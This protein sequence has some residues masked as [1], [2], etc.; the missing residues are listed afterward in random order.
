VD[1]VGTPTIFKR[2]KPSD[3]KISLDRTSLRALYDHIRMLDA[4]SYPKAFLE[5][6]SFRYE[7][8]KPALRTDNIIATVRITRLKAPDN[9]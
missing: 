5:Y 9:D 7:I 8:S 4:E 3:S 2:R 6:G 1:Q